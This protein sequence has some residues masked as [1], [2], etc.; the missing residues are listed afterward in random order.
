M[1]RPSGCFAFSAAG[2]PIRNEQ[3]GRTRDENRNPILQIIA[4][5][6][7]LNV[8]LLRSNRST[9][10]RGGQ[11]RSMPEEFGL[12]A[13]ALV[14]L[15]RW[16]SQSGRRSVP[17]LHSDGESAGDGP[18]DRRSIEK[19]RARNFHAHVG[20]ILLG[21]DSLMLHKEPPRNREAQAAKCKCRGRCPGESLGGCPP[22]P[23]AFV[24]GPPPSLPLAG[25]LPGD[26]LRL[27]I[28]RMDALLPAVS[29]F[30][31]LLEDAVHRTDGTQIPAFI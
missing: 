2:T 19:V 3:T 16:C 9:A 14:E 20:I 13:S 22:G 27:L 6:G 21:F 8:W 30:S 26:E 23:R 4:A 17:G 29:L 5:L 10:W 11:A 7:F 31:C 1:R 28:R 25:D 12:W 24:F 15:R 18:E